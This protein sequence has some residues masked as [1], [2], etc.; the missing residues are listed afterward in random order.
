MQNTFSFDFQFIPP[1]IVIPPGQV[2]Y[3]GYNFVLDSEMVSITSNDPSLSEF[4]VS[5][6]NIN[7]YLNTKDLQSDF[8]K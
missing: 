5:L 4:S 6:D 7:L 2:V 8:M 1:K 3:A